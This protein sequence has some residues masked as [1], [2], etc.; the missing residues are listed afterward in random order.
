MRWLLV[1]GLYYRSHMTMQQL[2]IWKTLEP[3]QHITKR[4]T[5]D[6]YMVWTHHIFGPWDDL[7]MLWHMSKIPLISLPLHVVGCHASKHHAYTGQI[8]TCRSLLQLEI[9]LCKT[10]KKHSHFNPDK[11]KYSTC[12]CMH[13]IKTLYLAGSIY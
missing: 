9:S 1:C 7:S 2:C 5:P 4:M 12:T 11:S 3:Y 13:E 8:Y 6:R 10:R